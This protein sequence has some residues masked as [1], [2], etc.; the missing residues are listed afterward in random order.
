MPLSLVV[1]SEHQIVKVVATGTVTFAEVRA[2]LAE[3]VAA[4]ALAMRELIDGTLAT[5]TF[6]AAEAQDIM[7]LLEQLGRNS[8]LG[9]TA[10]LV[11]NDV[12]YGMCRMLEIL[13]SDVC[14]LRPFRATEEKLAVDWLLGTPIRRGR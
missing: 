14:D 11:A 4:R 13:L 2:H 10:V 7:H 12:T 8:A 9:P 1:D 6:T 3:E 5:A